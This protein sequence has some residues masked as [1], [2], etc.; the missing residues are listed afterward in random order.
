MPVAFA[1][2]GGAFLVHEQNDWFFQRSSF[3][4]HVAGWTLVV[5]AVFPFLST[6]RPRSLSARGGYALTFVVLAVILFCDRDLA[7]VFGHLSPLAG[8]PHR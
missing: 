1:V 3:L 6:L 4:H 8:A 5:G 7:P 2:S